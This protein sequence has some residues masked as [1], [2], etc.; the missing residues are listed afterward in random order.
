MKPGEH[1]TLAP[2]QPVP[3]ATPSKPT[4]QAPALPVPEVKPVEPVAKKNKPAEWKAVT[5]KNWDAATRGNT[6][7]IKRLLADGMDVDVTDKGG[8]DCLVSCCTQ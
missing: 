4:A 5:G 8:A 3:E 1:V 7:L 2:A 6:K